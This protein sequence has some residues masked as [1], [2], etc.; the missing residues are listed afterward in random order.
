MNFLLSTNFISFVL[1][2]IVHVAYSF[3]LNSGNF[4]ILSA[5]SALTY[6]SISSVVCS[7]PEFVS[8]VFILVLLIFSSNSLWFDKIYGVVSISYYLQCV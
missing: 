1:N 3:S 2:R 4:L 8:L 7:F 6:F 5:I